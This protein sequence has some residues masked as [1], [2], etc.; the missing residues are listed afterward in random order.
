MNGLDK[1]TQKITEDAQAEVARINAEVMQDMDTLQRQI[2]TQIETQHEEILARGGRMAT[3][4]RA[5]LDSAARMEAKKL[6][7]SAR[8][9]LIGEAFELAVKTLC[10][11]PEGDYIALLTRLAVEASTTGQEALIFSPRDR[12][13]VGKQI[14]IAAN[15]ALAKDII[16]ELPA[17]LKSSKAGAFIEKMVSTAAIHLSDVA[18]LTLATETR[19]M[20]G[21]FILSDSNVDVN[22]TFETLV[23]LQ[24]ERLEREVA[25]ILFPS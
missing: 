9:E 25:T 15:E 17:S 8:Q 19:E 23:R 21:G 5:R 2:Q 13:R 4:R 6:N 18:S 7:L 3:E 16:P 10:D 12:T 24:R 1:I 22:C 11:I 20:A 14:V